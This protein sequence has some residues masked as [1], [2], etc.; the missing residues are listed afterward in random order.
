MT[1]K[2][3]YKAPDG[4]VSKLIE[5]PVLDKP[6]LLEQAS[7]NLCFAAS[8]SVF[9]MLLSNSEFKQASSYTHVARTAGKAVG[10]DAEGYRKEFLKLVKKASSIQK[11]A[12]DEDDDSLSNE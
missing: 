5:Q 4:D 9:G 7:E 12:V 10:I 3:R 1:V 11:V 6:V 2:F 8:V